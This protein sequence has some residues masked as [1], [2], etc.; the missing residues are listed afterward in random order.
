MCIPAAAATIGGMVLSTAL[1][2]G[3]TIMQA[4]QTAAVGRYN[5]EVA[6]VEA[7]RAREVG[8]LQEA[9]ARE[10]ITRDMARQRAAIARAGVS[11]TSP[12]SIDLG[13][14]AANTREMHLQ[15]IRS[16]AEDRARGLDAEARLSEYEAKS[17]K[18]AGFGQAG[19][20]LLRGASAWTRAGG[21]LL[22]S[23]GT[24][25]RRT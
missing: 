4:Q 12:T 19:A 21:D 3:G 9:Q 20:T 14:D 2:V 15:G 7:D 17:A 25:K 24:T 10:T 11:I 22:P 8:R 5:A 23:I 18:I 1:S 6:R 16:Q 13:A